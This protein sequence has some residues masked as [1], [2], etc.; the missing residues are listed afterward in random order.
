LPGPKHIGFLFQN[1]QAA[2]PRSCENA[3]V[4]PNELPF[5]EL[6]AMQSQFLR[7]ANDQW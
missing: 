1:F 2:L 3:G 6:L 5:P 7:D 4:S